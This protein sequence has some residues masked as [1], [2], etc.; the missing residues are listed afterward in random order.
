MEQGVE[1]IAFF[2]HLESGVFQGVA[3][4]IHIAF[5]RPPITVDI[6][7]FDGVITI[8]SQLATGSLRQMRCG[9]TV[10]QM[11]KG[12]ELFGSGDG[13]YGIERIFGF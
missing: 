11:D 3:I 2:L 9:G 8:L 10:T 1:Q 5:D 12:D 6:I 13:K 7:Y 4:R